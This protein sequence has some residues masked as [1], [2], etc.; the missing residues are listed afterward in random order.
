MIK[1]LEMT[2]KNL[3]EASSKAETS[4]HLAEKQFKETKTIY[5]E[6]IGNLQKAYS[7]VREIRSESIR[8]EKEAVANLEKCEDFRMK[9]EKLSRD[10]SEK[11][12][13]NSNLG[14][15]FTNLN[16]RYDK[17]VDTED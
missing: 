14:L 15:S 13:E 16:N 4:Q 1:K 5:D 2:V 6:T 10:Y 11:V 8:Y 17:L 12:E 7:D 9:Y 3:E